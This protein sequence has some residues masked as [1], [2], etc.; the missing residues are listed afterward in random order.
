MG[1][2][3]GVTI[4]PDGKHV[5]AIVRCDA[6]A[7]DR[8]GDEC[9][10]S[11]LD[12]V[13]KFDMDGNVVESF[14]GGMFIW[15]HGIDVAPDG[16]VWVTDGARPAKI[17]PGSKRGHRV[18][19]FSQTG[20]V[21][22]VLGTP[23]KA[24]AGPDR[25]M[26]PADVVVA[27]SGEIFVA[28]GHVD[29]GNNRVVKFAKNGKYIKEWGKTGS[30][31]GE[32]RTL[33]AIAMDSR[34][35]I[36]VGDRSNNRIQIFDREGAFLA[37]WS[38]FG[39]PSGIFI[40]AEDRIYVADSESDNLEN[41]GWRW[42][43]AWAT[44]ARAGSNRSFFTRGATRRR[45]EDTARSSWPPTATAICTPASLAR[46]SCASTSACGREA[47]RL[48]PRAVK[49]PARSSAEAVRSGRSTSRNCRKISSTSRSSSSFSNLTG[50]DGK[51]CACALIGAA[52]PQNSPYGSPSIVAQ[53]ALRR[54]LCNKR[55]DE[56]TSPG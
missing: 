16:S 48:L 52:S 21:L 54:I 24:G 14:G 50:A 35:R 38:Q 41:P 2:V 29:E 34:G 19:K 11:D 10:D 12:P 56:R 33:H 18:V 28:D 55:S 45:P 46:A 1:A 27:D 6:T 23:G 36:F 40:D 47:A 44:R 5:W 39:R 51:G 32:F 13:L 31:P 20:E 42:A 3:G 53:R 15:P 17:P 49:R 7:L 25:F 9:L 22:M 26:S 37:E 4:D 8:F 43:S 30:A